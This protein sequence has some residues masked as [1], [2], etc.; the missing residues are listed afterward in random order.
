MHCDLK[1]EN[2]L[3]SSKDPDAK[4]TIIDMGL[5]Q[6]LN[7]DEYLNRSKGTIYY[8]APEMLMGKYNHKVD[9]WACGVILYILITGEF[10][11][12]AMKKDSNKKLI[13]D[14]EKTSVK[15]LNDPVSF[16]HEN[17]KTVD[18]D[19]I[20]LLSHMLN[21]NPVNRPEAKELLQHPWFDKTT[22]DELRLEGKTLN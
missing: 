5:G 12:A 1:P 17:F 11:F 7:H 9:I 19:V 13:L 4:L 18:P 16:A 2:I 8:V 15:I 22:E 20:Y 21:K 14:R 6:Y 10:P 3:L